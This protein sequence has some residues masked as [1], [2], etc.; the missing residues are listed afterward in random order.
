MAGFGMKPTLDGEL[1]QLRPFRP[2][3]VDGIR[4]ALADPETR[5]LTGSSH[6][7]FDE[8]RLTTWY[9]TRNEQDDRLDLAVADRASGRCVGEVVLNEVDEHNRSC[10]FRTLIGPAGRGRGLGTEAVRLTIAYG[11]E[12]LG[13]H[14][15]GL[16]VYAFN[17]RARRVY[18]KAGF[19]VE[20]VLRD[21]LRYGDT[22]VDATVMSILATEWN[23]RR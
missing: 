4:A 1:V 16:E 13:L 11:F 8:D 7:A 17:T 6:L 18:E 3:D 23:G 19:V 22:W 15:I 10:N 20:G 14:R 12:Q 2:E 9:G 5:M 21:V